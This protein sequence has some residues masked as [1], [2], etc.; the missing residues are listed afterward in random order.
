MHEPALPMK[1]R[2]AIGG[3]WH[4]TNGFAAGLTELADFHAY[5]Y[6]EGV[7]LLE[8]YRG[9]GTELGGMIAAAEDCA[10]ELLPTVFAGA[11]PSATICRAGWFAAVIA[12]RRS[13]NTA[14]SVASSS[15]VDTSA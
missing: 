4:E 12:P 5:Q 6:A 3:I 9:T 10:F 7:A 8:R 1:K 2:I 15:S 13:R 11:V 14:P